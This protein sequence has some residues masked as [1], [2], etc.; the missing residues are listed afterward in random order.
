MVRQR[1][2][3]SRST[4]VFVD[5]GC[6]LSSVLWDSKERQTR[7]TTVRYMLTFYAIENEWMVL[8]QSEREVGIADIGQW[9][10]EPRRA[11]KIGEGQRLRR[12]TMTVR[13]VRVRR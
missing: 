10:V 13:V 9:F 12:G 5:P 11:G 8:R 4:N 6:R 2:G 1:S 3:S 7:R